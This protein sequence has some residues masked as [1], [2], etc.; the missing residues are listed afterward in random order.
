MT[1]IYQ[2]FIILKNDE[3]KISFIHRGMN[4]Y[5]IKNSINKY[6]YIL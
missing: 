5:S 2:I 3:I 1:Y 4:I 6:K